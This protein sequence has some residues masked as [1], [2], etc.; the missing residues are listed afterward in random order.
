M[1]TDQKKH[2]HKEMSQK[3]HI[4]NIFTI[5]ACINRPLESTQADNTLKCIR[6]RAVTFLET[7]EINGG[8]DPPSSTFL[9]FSKAFFHGFKISRYVTSLIRGGKNQN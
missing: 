1:E 5:P 4:H 9:F 7:L 6:I 8:G 2:T 3:R